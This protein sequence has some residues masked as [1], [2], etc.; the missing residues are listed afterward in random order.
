MKKRKK[1]SRQKSKKPSAPSQKAFTIDDFREPK[2]LK[3]PEVLWTLD[4][5]DFL[6]V[7]DVIAMVGSD[8]SKIEEWCEENQAVFGTW[9][10]HKEMS[11]EYSV[12]IAA[13]KKAN[14]T[15]VVLLGV[16]SGPT[17]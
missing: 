4:G 6:V 10:S 16:N 2:A 3:P 14:R 1:N 7:G 12:F 5:V 9:D 13:A 8:P 11:P 15:K 17:P